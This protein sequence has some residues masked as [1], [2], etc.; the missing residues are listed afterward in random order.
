MSDRSNR[1]QTFDLAES[2][3][4]DADVEADH[5]LLASD[6]PASVEWLLLTGSRWV[7]SGGLVLVYLLGLLGLLELGIIATGNGSFLTRLFASLIGSI[8]TLI[9]V[10]ISINQLII[11]REF[12]SPG[13]L[14]EDIRE[15]IA[16]RQDVAG[17]VDSNTTPTT[18]GAFLTFLVILLRD[19]AASLR[20]ETTP[21]SGR[22]DT[23]LRSFTERLIAQAEGIRRT[24]DEPSRD[25]FETLVVVLNTDFSTDLHDGHQIQTVHDHSLSS[26]LES[27]LEQVLDILEHI[28]V[29]RQ[30]LKTLYF[31]RTLTALSRDILY[32]GLPALGLLVVAILVLS[33][34]SGPTLDGAALNA[35]VLGTLTVAAAPVAVFCTY[36][37][38]IATITRRTGAVLPFVMPDEP[39]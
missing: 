1:P 30:H 3:R 11:S 9:T 14:R 12:S 15:T 13:Q 4:T 17:L 27:Q 29:A 28:G 39:T 37:L 10:V 19:E 24:V 18:P 35:L 22:A 31:Q 25:P 21:T 33:G 6:V 38:R 7:V 36:V 34:P 32:V 26:D 5:E 8:V 23:A 20:E 2:E 16:Y